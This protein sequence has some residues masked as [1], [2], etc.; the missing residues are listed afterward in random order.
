M[1]TLARR[2]RSRPIPFER[3]TD[4]A[5]TATDEDLAG[6]PVDTYR[7]RI[8]S[9]ELRDGADAAFGRVGEAILALRL[10]P[11]NAITLAADSTHGR[12]AVGATVLQ[13]V[14]FGPFA[15]ESAVR[16]T[17]LETSDDTD[18]ETVSLTWATLD[19]HPERGIET[20]SAT[21]GPDGSIILTI[22]ARSRPGTRLVRLGTPF[23]RWLQR[24]YSRA[25]LA[26][27]AAIARGQPLE[28]V[29]ERSR[30][31]RDGRR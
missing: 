12:A 9:D 16:L 6:W 29:S 25:A 27:L 19:G 23:A 8:P 5:V 4:R 17:A 18:R 28:G 13:R 10:F 11:E 7:A 22:R 21:R 20:F 2:L 24:R 30:P 26:H 31:R 3:W 14:T 15:L 1:P